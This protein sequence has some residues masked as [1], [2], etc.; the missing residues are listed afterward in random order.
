MGCF[1]DMEKTKEVN[2]QT[3]Q[4]TSPPAWVESASKSN[5]D[6]ARSML[7]QGFQPY[8][9]NLVAPL[10][11][12]ERAA[13]NIVAQLAGT[14][15]GSPNLVTSQQRISDAGVAPAFNYDFS[16]VVDPSLIG[17]IDSYMN[18]YLEQV[19]SPTLRKIQEAGVQQRQGINANATAAGA[20]GDARHGVVEGQQMRDENQVV[21]DTTGKAFNDAF[22][23]AMGLRTSDLQRLFGTQQAQQSANESALSRMRQ[24][25]I[26]LSSLDQTELGRL[27][28]LTS[29]LGQT[30]ANERNVEQ[31]QNTA[32]YNEFLRKTNFTND[33]IAFLT[34][35]LSGTPVS[36]TV[37]GDSTETTSQPDNSGW[38]A[39]GSIA[40]ALFSAI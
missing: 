18:P 19:L 32:D 5:Y 29:A 3:T 24:S 23:T 21:A 16:T 10:S 34:S 26:D 37:T 33:E 11:D 22:T 30:G 28:G 2:K 31:A 13:G 40:G 1:G 20:Y 17:S 6:L 38:G 39:V 14:G 4:T 35:I 12:N 27:L 9:N 7:D 25:G 36:K 8:S 15:G